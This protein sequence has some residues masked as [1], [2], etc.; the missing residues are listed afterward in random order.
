GY[1][2]RVP[3]ETYKGQ[4]RGGK[5]VAGMATKEE[6][7]VEH[8]FVANTHDYILFFT[9]AGQA[10][11]K[12]VY[13]IPEASRTA[14]GKAIV[15]LLNI[16]N[17]ETI[18]AMIRVREFTEDKHLVMATANGVVKKTNLAAFANV[19]NTSIIAIKV[20]EGDR[21]I[22]VMLT[23]GASDVILATRQGKSLR[24]AETQL[25][26]QGRATRGVKGITLRKGDLVENMEIVNDLATFLVCTENGYGK[27]SAFDEYR[28]QKRGGT[29]IISI[30]TSAR[31]GEVVGAHAVMETD[32]LM[33]ITAQGKMIRMSVGDMR[34]IGRAT[35]GVR[36]I[37]LDKGD[38]LVSATTVEPE[39][40]SVLDQP[41]DD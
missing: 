13:E 18:A 6:D 16:T 12:K 41:T 19:R 11:W 8:L 27:R 4:R 1:I 9:S 31:N 33:L 5:G 26:D 35:Q 21:L 2:K 23:D 17:E 24:F 20:D 28:S 38:K 34:V 3:I 39:D 32:A 36:L 29:G 14:R 7:F 37:N 15:N 10:F 22:E 40:E 30:R 25:R